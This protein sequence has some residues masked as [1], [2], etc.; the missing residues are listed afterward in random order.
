[1]PRMIEPDVAAG[2][3]LVGPDRDDLLG[4]GAAEVLEL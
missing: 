1:M 3:D 4:A 2:P